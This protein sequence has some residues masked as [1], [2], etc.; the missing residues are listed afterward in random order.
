[1]TTQEQLREQFKSSTVWSA[2]LANGDM[3]VDPNEL[4]T[5]ME[6][7][8][9]QATKE[10]VEA[11]GI[12]RE[13]STEARQDMKSASTNHDHNYYYNMGL[14]EGYEDAISLIDEALSIPPNSKDEM[15]HQH[16]KSCCYLSPCGCVCH[17]IPPNADRTGDKGIIK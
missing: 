6:R 14:V 15:Y 16:A 8:I 17:S 11:V 4:Y 9:S 13:W 1:M 10:A 12:L 3:V 7:F 5:F 2:I